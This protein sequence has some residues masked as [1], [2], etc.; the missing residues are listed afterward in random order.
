[1]TQ[2]NHEAFVHLLHAPAAAVVLVFA[3]NRLNRVEAS[4]RLYQGMAF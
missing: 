3:V 2:Q 1:M 4:A